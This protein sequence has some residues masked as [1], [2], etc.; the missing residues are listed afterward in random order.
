MAPMVASTAVSLSDEATP[1]V[2]AGLSEGRKLAIFLVMAVGQFMAV[3]DI[4]IVAASMNSIQAGLSAAADEIDWLQTA[5]LMAEIVMI[6]LSAY[7]AQ[8]LSTRWMFVASAALFTI[9]SLMCG[10][11]WDLPSMLVFRIV[12]GFVGGAMIPLVFATGFSFFDG[13]Q[14]VMATSVLGVISTLSPTL[15]PAVGGWITDMVSW[16]WLFFINVAPGAMVTIALVMLGPVD[17]ARPSMLARID[18]L[19]A[20]SLAVFL[21]GL[22]YVL[23]EGPRHGWFQD[24]GIATVGWL[25]AVG[26]VVFVE[27][28]L[29]SPSPLVSLAPFRRKG[30]AAAGVMAFVTGLGLYAITFLAPVFL[31]RVRDFSSLEIGVTTFVSGVFMTAAAPA[32]AWLGTRIDLRI[33]MAIG[34]VLFGASFWMISAVGSDWGFWELFWTQA[35]RGVGVLFCMVP[36][37]SMA[38]NNLPDE[39]LKPASGLNNLMRN[40]GGALGIALVNTG[41]QRYFAWHVQQLA[42]G[43]G[44]APQDALAAVAGLAQ[45]L[46]A[47]LPNPDQAPAAARAAISGLV[48]REALTGAFQ[49]VFRL[50]A[51]AFIIALV[52]VPFCQGGSMMPNQNHHHH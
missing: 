36:S 23:E 16:R 47:N 38:L 33:V 12:Q 50:C 19:H 25:A 7:L 2:G 8:A 1:K 5:Y 26:A 11:A 24:A 32:A 34:L 49:D 18:W 28:C 3:L 45:R 29:F 44:R 13:P 22:Q 46:A 40:L 4:Q 52:A 27:R 31:A 48:A 37:V 51:Y 6:P 42:Q 15:G 9:S 17:R 43:L 21:G 30:F 14:R 41:L 39:E 20:A 10:A 35:V